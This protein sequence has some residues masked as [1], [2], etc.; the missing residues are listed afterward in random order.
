M[1]FHISADPVYFGSFYNNFVNSIK[2]N[3]KNFKISLNFVGNLESVEV[4]ETFILTQDNKTFE[5]ICD[6]YSSQDKDA[7]GYYALSRWLSI[8]VVDEDI[9]VCDIDILAVNPIDQDLISNLLVDYPVI[10]C[11]RFKP[12]SNSQGGM[13]AMVLRRDVC[14]DIRDYANSLLITEK[15]E[16]L[17]D[18]KVRS[19]IYKN[20][21]VKELPQ[22]HDISKQGPTTD[23][24]FVFSKINKFGNLTNVRS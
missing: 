2:I 23:K 22:M 19:F 24:W 11:T 6:L 20:Y 14:K 18:T 13:M 4:P 9:F 12:K 16:W 10:N 1:I 7:K 17:T 5:N 21:S 3:Y 8:P 15:L